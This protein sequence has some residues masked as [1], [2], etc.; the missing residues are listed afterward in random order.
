MDVWRYPVTWPAFSKRIRERA[1]YRCQLIGEGGE[2]MSVER[3]PVVADG[4]DLAFP[5]LSPH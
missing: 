4:H 5:D 2:L 1:G 3:V